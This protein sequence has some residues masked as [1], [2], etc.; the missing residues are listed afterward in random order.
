MGSRLHCRYQDS[1]AFMHG[2]QTHCVSSL[3]SLDDIDMIATAGAGVPDPDPHA[4][5]DPRRLLGGFRHLWQHSGGPLDIQYLASMTGRQS[6]RMGLDRC[7]PSSDT[8]CW[9]YSTGPAQARA[10]ACASGL[11][12]HLCLQ[13]ANKAL[14]AWRSAGEKSHQITWRSAASAA[15]KRHCMDE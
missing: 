5:S 11:A 2:P 4:G 15:A 3:P 13:E 14:H 1:T 7:Q 6:A 12:A 9:I 8:L 10:A